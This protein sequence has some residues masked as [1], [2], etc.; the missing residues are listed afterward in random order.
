MPVVASAGCC[1]E[2]EIPVEGGWYREAGSAKCENGNN[3]K[4]N[5]AASGITG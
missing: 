5:A 4:R 1:R 3:R 2:I